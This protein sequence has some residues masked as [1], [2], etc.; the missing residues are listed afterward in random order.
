MIR[1]LIVLIHLVEAGLKSRRNLLLEN[2]AL[3]HQLLVLRRSS[4][5]LRLTLIDRVLSA[6]LSV[7]WDSWRIRLCLVQPSTASTLGY[8]YRKKTN[9]TMISRGNMTG[10][11]HL[12]I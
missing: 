6:W 8:S 10:I 3:R 9:Q 4:N 7:V 2:L 5:R 11:V 12:K 1:W